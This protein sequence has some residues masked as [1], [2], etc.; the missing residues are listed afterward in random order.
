MTEMTES[1]TQAETEGVDPPLVGGMLLALQTPGSRAR[2]FASLLGYAERDYLLLRSSPSHPGDLRAMRLQLGDA[3]MVRF[4]EGGTA[5][6]FRVHVTRV[7]QQPELLV[8]TSV[9]ASAETRVLRREERIPCMIP[10]Q[11]AGAGG[12][13]AVGLLLDLSASGCQLAVSPETAAPD[14]DA[15]AA[16]TLS[17]ALPGSGETLELSGR[18]RRHEAREAGHRLGLQFDEAGASAA[19]QALEAVR[20]L[21]AMLQ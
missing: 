8:F 18:V 21:A 15:D 14:A 17:L 13:P 6:G 10:C 16:L 3:L 11:V 2:R 19:L 12:E 1:S 20:S 9:P 5:Y 4:L 7:L